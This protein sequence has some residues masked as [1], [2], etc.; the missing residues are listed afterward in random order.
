MHN[1]NR[2]KAAYGAVA[3]VTLACCLSMAPALAGD[4]QPLSA[5]EIVF[6]SENK[7]I[8]NTMKAD[9]TMRLINGNGEERVR[10]MQSFRKNYGD[11]M[12]DEKNIYF[13]QYPQDIKD[14]AYLSYDW[15]DDNVD[16][17]SWIFLPAL[18]KV[19]RLAEADKSD[20]F[21]GSDFTYTDIKT[22]KREYWDYTMVKESDTVDGHDCWVV[23]GL[24]K[25]GREKKV[26][27][28][29]GYTKV[30]IWVRKDNFMKVKGTFWVKEGN[31]IKYFSASDIEQIAG[32]WT[33][34]VN[35]IWTTK[36]ERVEHT[37]VLELANIRYNEP[38]DDAFFTPQRMT[39]GL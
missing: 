24:P 12:K 3:Y 36:H 38:T 2:L 16:D 14:T 6:K 31:K 18:K 34:K 4:G 29:T 1:R 22:H 39:R 23:E 25:K 19:K 8:G 5:N 21:L 15:D 35:K 9:L 7:D 26:L 27:N 11:S 32:I 33:A 30:H 17:D 10:K 28:E 20:A 37:T 13:F